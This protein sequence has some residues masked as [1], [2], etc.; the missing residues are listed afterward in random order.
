MG[1]SREMAQE[2]HV[3]FKVLIH[4]MGIDYLMTAPM[5]HLSFSK[6]G[7]WTNH[8]EFMWK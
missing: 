5:T 8:T 2:L 7:P 1:W 6:C 4:D 3:I